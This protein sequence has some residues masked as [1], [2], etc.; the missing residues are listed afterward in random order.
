MKIEL[1]H[2]KE[3]LLKESADLEKQLATLGRKNPDNPSDWE[4]IKPADG[5]DEADEGEV[6]DSIEQYENNSAEL[7]QLEIQLKDVKS[8]LEKIEKGTYG[9]CEVGGEEI[10][11]DRLE[12]NPAART[13]KVHMNREV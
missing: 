9:I 1:Q 4:A 8:A 12:A 2:I 6:A 7:E 10:E 5:V 13:C 11:T 3:R